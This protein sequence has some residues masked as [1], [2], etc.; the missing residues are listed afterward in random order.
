MKNQI[1]NPNPSRPAALETIARKER[2]DGDKVCHKRMDDMIKSFTP[3]T[4]L[5]VALNGCL[6]TKFLLVHINNKVISRHVALL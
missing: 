6:D 4:I 1:R 2:R 5:I 3:S